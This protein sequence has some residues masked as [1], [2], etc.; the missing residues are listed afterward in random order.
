[1]SGIN[2]V[3]LL[4]RLGAD[5]DV[6]EFDGGGKV[7][8]IPVATSEKWKDKTT[9]EDRER[10]E[11]HKVKIFAKGAADFAEKYLRKGDSAYIEGKL[12]TKKWQTQ[13]GENRYELQVCVRPYKGEIVK[14]RSA[15]DKAEAPRDEDW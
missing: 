10:T 11:W 12:E 6:K 13:D 4:G 2:K 3:V 14:V 15:G 8:T 7:V 5:P 1:M 9:G